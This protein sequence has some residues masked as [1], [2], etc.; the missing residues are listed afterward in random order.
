MSGIFASCVFLCDS[1]YW[2]NL[3][4]CPLLIYNATRFAARD[5]K[6][7]FITRGEYKAFKRMEFQFQIKSFLYACLFAWSLVMLI[8]KCISF[9]GKI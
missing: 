4:S 8:L 5:H 9:F 7:Y 1:P 6:Q 3:I 2:C